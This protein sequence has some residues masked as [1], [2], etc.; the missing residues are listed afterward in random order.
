MGPWAHG[1]MGRN[2]RESSAGLEGEIV[3]AAPRGDRERRF[4]QR[5][6]DRPGGGILGLSRQRG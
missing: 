4:K 3:G 2:T 5:V 1:P 6:A